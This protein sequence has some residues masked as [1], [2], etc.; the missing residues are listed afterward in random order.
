MSVLTEKR[1]FESA[2]I[3]ID[4]FSSAA[5]HNGFI[6]FTFTPFGAAKDIPLAG[7]A[8]DFLLHNG[9]DVIAFKS[10]RNVWYQNVPPA[11]LTVVQQ[12]LSGHTIQYQ[13]R[14]G[15]G[16]SMGGYAAIQFSGD[17]HFDTVLALSPQ[18]EID[19][20]YDRRWKKFARR[21]TF[22]YRIDRQSVSPHCRYF[23]AYDP[24]NVDREHI[25]RL[26]ELIDQHQL[27]RIPIPHSGHPSTYF[28]AEIGLIQDL[29]LSIL[30]DGAVN[31]HSMLAHRRRSKTYLSEMSRHL[32]NRRKYHSALIAI[33]RAL[34]I[35]RS[36]AQ[37]HLQ[38]SIILDALLRPDEALAVLQQARLMPSHDAYVLGMI[39]KRLAKHHC[40]VEA[41]HIEYSA[42]CIDSTFASLQLYNSAFRIPKGDVAGAIDAGE[43]AILQQPQS[44]SLLSCVGVLH[45]RKWGFDHWSRGLA[46]LVR[47]LHLR[48]FTRSAQI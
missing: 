22:Q 41:L 16:T 14:V 33:E 35:D 7:Y 20:P 3:A 45:L 46:L 8:G 39:A 23:V 37:F 26:A 43:I 38:K 36:V 1:L 40:Y 28:F 2:D 42:I 48:F 27:V 10:T 32:A 21:I 44:P 5:P 47:A 18:F 9:F 25:D 24:K 11:A 31:H 12:F 6:A 30:R 13:K 15:Y 34:Q 19:Q 4:F 29:A 17:L